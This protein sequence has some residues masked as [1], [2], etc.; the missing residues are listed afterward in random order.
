MPGSRL[1]RSL[2]GLLSGLLFVTIVLC[3]LAH[4]WSAAPVRP[5]PAAATAPAWATAPAD[6]TPHGPHPHHGNEHCA[7]DGG[8][9]TT[10]QATPQTP[11]DAGASLPA[12]LFGVVVALSLH[13]RPH[14]FRTR[15]TGRTTLVRTSR[16]RI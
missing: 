11:A 5:A 3:A 7:L 6:A 4:G 10:A 13:R 14:R 12:R 16:W 9:R 1:P 2:V 8:A 15:R